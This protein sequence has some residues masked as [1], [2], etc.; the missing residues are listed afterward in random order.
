MTS[1][2]RL[3]PIR[4]WTCPAH[5]TAFRCGG[6]ASVRD[7]Q[8]VVTGF[9][10]G[11]RNTTVTR[12]ALAG[13]AAALRDLPSVKDP[14]S[15]E[16]IRVETSSPELAALAGARAALPADSGPD[17]DLWVR[18]HADSAGRRLEVVMAPSRPETAIAFV[19]AWAEVAMNKAKTSGPFSTAIPKPNLAR[20]PGLG[21]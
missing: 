6:W 2:I 20:M 4:L 1:S 13:L 7:V 19:A 8:G 3:P 9:A 21:R 14:T 16:P 17:L 5:H 12:M 11:Q 15:G 10:G 18:I